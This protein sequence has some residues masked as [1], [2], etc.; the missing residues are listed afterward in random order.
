MAFTYCCIWRA[1]MENVGST[2]PH[3]FPSITFYHSFVN[4]ILE[5]PETRATPASLSPLLQPN[6]HRRR[7]QPPWIIFS[8]GPST[9]L[10]CSWSSS[11]SALQAC[12]FWPRLRLGMDSIPTSKWHNTTFSSPL[13]RGLCHP[14]L[15]AVANKDENLGSAYF[16]PSFFFFSFLLFFFLF[17]I[18]GW[19]FFGG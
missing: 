6:R 11:S 8:M 13:H 15:R 1:R 2:Y 18:H 14:T 4:S 12:P 10:T 7:R 19:N 9:P 3:R 5:S 16:P 17:F